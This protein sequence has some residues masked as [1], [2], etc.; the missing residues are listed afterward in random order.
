MTVPC[1][2]APGG[3]DGPIGCG[4]QG[5]TALGVGGTTG[6][7]SSHLATPGSLS[8]VQQPWA[9]VLPPCVARQLCPLP[10]RKPPSQ[11]LAVREQALL[12]SW[13][14]SVSSA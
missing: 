7:W 4:R 12:V 8:L 5:P 3:G 14:G 2:S 6:D 11:G 13:F 10:T 9:D 1:P